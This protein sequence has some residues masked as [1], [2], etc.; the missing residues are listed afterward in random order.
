L[1]HSRQITGADYMAVTDVL[2]EAAE[3][4]RVSDAVI[5]IGAGASH[6]AGMP[7]AGQ[8][9]PLVW[10]TLDQHPSFA[11]PWPDHW[12]LTMCRRRG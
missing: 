5:L 10:H 1:L 11:A 8:L 4:I 7:M 3:E 2:T 6:A 12:V 9:S